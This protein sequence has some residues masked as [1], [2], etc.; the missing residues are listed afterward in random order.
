MK[1][2]IIGGGA[3]GGT[4]AQFA[5]KQDRRAEIKVISSEGYGQYSKCGLPYALS[6][7]IPVEENLI[8][9]SPGWFEKNKIEY[10]RNSRVVSI[11]SHSKKLRIKRVK[12]NADSLSGKD[13]DNTAKVTNPAVSEYEESYDTLII[14]TGASASIP[15]IK[16]IDAVKKGVFTLREMEDVK[17]IKKFIEQICES[18]GAKSEDGSNENKKLNA[19][20]I[21]AG[22][23]GLEAAEALHEKGMD[24]TVVEYCQSVLPQMV[25]PDIA[26]KITQKLNASGIRVLTGHKVVSVN[27]AKSGEWQVH[28]DGAA[29]TKDTIT[30]VQVEKASLSPSSSESGEK[31]SLTCNLLIVAAGQRPNTELAASAGIDIGPARGIKVDAQCRTNIESVFACGDCTEYPDFITGKPVAIG[32]GTIAARQGKVA[33]INAAGGN[34]SMPSGILNTRCTKLFDY[35][36]AAVGP[37]ID[38]LEKITGKKPVV[39][40]MTARSLPHYFPGGE[41][42]VVKLAVDPETYQILAAQAVGAGAYGR[43]N[44]FASAILSKTDARAFAMLETCYAPPVAPTFDALTLSCDMVLLKMERKRN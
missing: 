39:A 32:M 31:V 14:A 4:A 2:V 38:T 33:G 5:R 25:D 12:K 10:V 44:T 34:A 16:N 3:A 27:C 36:I 8:E 22:L 17:K 11:D 15:P 9:F 41:E 24:V 6:G 30:D 21:G 19:V 43:I 13:E 1:I 42:V 40:T 20:V 26:S 35:E 23:I 28:S 37:L 18:S 7:I 29:G